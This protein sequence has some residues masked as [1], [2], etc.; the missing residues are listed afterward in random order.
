MSKKEAM[1]QTAYPHYV[2][3]DD[4]R[5]SEESLPRAFHERFLAHFIGQRSDDGV[6]PPHSTSEAARELFRDGQKALHE[7]KDAVA[8]IRA[9]EEALDLDPGYLQVWVAL[10]IAYITDNTEDGLDQ[11]EAILANLCALPVGENGL[12]REA[13]SII[14]QN[15]AYLHLHRW[16]RG[17]G[18]RHLG[19]ADA[20]YAKADALAEAPRIELLCPWAFVKHERGELTAARSLVRRAEA[21]NLPGLLG[22]YAAKYAPLTALRGGNR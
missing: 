16:R 13:A 1:T 6:W 20:L 4:H 2:L 14:H 18:L 17:N 8:A 22:E 21:L 10:A 7:S 5:T 19:E 11:A 3:Q 15:R 12:T 9:Y